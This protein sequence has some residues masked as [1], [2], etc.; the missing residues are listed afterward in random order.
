VSEEQQEEP[1]GVEPEWSG[2]VEDQDS[3]AETP[4]PSTVGTG[5]YIAISCTVMAFLVTFLILGILFLL[6]WI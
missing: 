2:T 6:R 3:A 4:P 1:S 5:S